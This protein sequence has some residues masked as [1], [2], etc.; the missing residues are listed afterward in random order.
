MLPLYMHVYAQIIES[1]TDACR[2]ARF[3]YF[4]KVKLSMGD[5]A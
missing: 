4:M 2:R 3:N 5:M 1:E